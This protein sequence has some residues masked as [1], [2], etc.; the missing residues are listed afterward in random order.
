MSIN[1]P[2]HWDAADWNACRVNLPAL[3]PYDTA[4]P[5]APSVATVLHVLTGIRD[6]TGAPAPNT[7]TIPAVL[8]AIAA[9][10]PG[11]GPAQYHGTVELTAGP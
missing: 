4:N 10:T 2:E 3:A 11:A 6:G 5:A 1:G 8:A 7:S 9:L